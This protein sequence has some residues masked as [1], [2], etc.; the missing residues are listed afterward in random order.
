MAAQRMSLGEAI[1]RSNSGQLPAVDSHCDSVSI[2]IKEGG[3]SSC[4]SH[5]SNKWLKSIME[6][7]NKYLHSGSQKPKI[8]MVQPFLREV[9]TNK[10]SY[11]PKVVSIGPCHHGKQELQPIEMLKKPMVLLFVEKRKEKIQ[12]LYEE[13][14]KVASDARKCYAEGLTERFNDE[15]FTHMML[16]DGCFIL[17]YICSIVEGNHEKLKKIQQIALVRRD[18]LLLENQLP[19]LVLRVLMSARF[20]IAEGEEMITAFIKRIRGVPP[21]EV[22][23]M[24]QIKYFI[25][26]RSLGSK[27]HPEV[28]MPD[29][30][31]K[32]DDE[33]VHLLELVRRQFID[34]KAFGFGCVISSS[35][36]SRRSAK[37]F[38]TV[39]IHCKPSRTCQ[40]TD[41]EFKSK[42]SYGILTLPP[43]IIDDSTKSMLLNL[44][45][46]EVCPDNANDLGVTSYICFMNSI[47]DQDEDVKELRSQGIVMNYLGSDMQ[48]AD[49]F[50]DITT[51]LAPSPHAYLQVKSGIEKHHR[52]SWKSWIAEW[53]HTY[54]RS[55]W[56]C[57]AVA[58]AI[59]AITL[60]VAQ[61]V[62]AAYQT[63]LTTHPPNG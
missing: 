36:Y 4:C 6:E 39:G 57:I 3:E 26:Q 54:F 18:L 49:L 8:Q 42:F 21:K 22:A 10:K 28:Q 55:P 47:I 43:I 44:A 41:I 29:G 37:D 11:D 12:E 23:L 17:H 27:S 38:K 19:F 24:E 15:E 63:Y 34:P 50:S 58:A 30:K 20:G 9:E 56:T 14:V 59:L 33:P 45:A 1:E 25:R 5:S 46:Y 32:D 13:V 60:S 2:E 62:L 51:E 7:G 52:I 53:H 16:L 35:W 40:F 48:V 61:T 31:D